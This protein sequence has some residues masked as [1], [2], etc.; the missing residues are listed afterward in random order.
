VKRLQA[1]GGLITLLGAIVLLVVA[2]S[3]WAPM[4]TDTDASPT[5]YNNGSAGAKAAYL[6]LEKLGYR[7]ERWERPTADLD[8]LHPMDT[9]LVL[10]GPYMQNELHPESA[11]TRFVSSGGRVVATGLAGALLLPQPHAAPS[12]RIY[13]ALCL[14]TPGSLSPLGRAGGVQMRSAAQWL[15]SDRKARVQ[16]WCG[17]EAAVITYPYGKGE[18]IWWASSTPLSNAGLRKDGSLRLLLAAVG[19]R[20]RTVIFDEYVHGM[21]DEV[22]STM[23]GTPVRAL[24]VQ[25]ALVAVLM[26]LSFSRRNGPVR[27]RLLPRRTSPVEFALSMGGLYERAHATQVATGVARQRLLAFL[28]HEAGLPREVVRSSPEAIAG[29]VEARFRCDGKSLADA[30]RAAHAAQ[31]AT[32]SGKSALALV[33]TLDEQIERLR[34]IAAP[35]KDAE[36]NT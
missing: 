33:R 16:Q 15:R 36:R 11:V 4:V 34:K 22:W 32:L 25:V 8:T 6:L 9:T 27:E 29:S 7:V 21:R 12:Q 31:H 10:A 30:L 20:N 3:I 28:E 2:G 13:T 24:L 35:K 23:R 19:E 1:K 17:D 14:T 5:T 18:V 26:L